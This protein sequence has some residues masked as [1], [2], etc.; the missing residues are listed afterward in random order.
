[1]ILAVGHTEYAN[2]GADAL[3]AYGREG[4]VFYDL[5]SLFPASASD[6]RL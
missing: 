5:K 2:A 3:R 6:L 4:A 1:V